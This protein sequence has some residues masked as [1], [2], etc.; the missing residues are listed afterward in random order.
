MVIDPKGYCIFELAKGSASCPNCRSVVQPRTAGFY[1]CEYAPLPAT[2][3]H[4][5]QAL[6][7]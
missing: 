2:C 3:A 4:R 1:D 6:P 5:N 7:H